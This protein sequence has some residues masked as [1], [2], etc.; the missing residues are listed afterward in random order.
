MFLQV[1]S[2]PEAAT[3][4]LKN[5]DAARLSGVA[6][7]YR[8]MAFWNEVLRSLLEDESLILTEERILQRAHSFLHKREPELF[9]S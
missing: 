9:S 7:T 1:H 6:W 3:D 2:R 5:E 8:N 4:V